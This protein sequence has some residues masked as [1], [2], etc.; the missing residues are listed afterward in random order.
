[1]SSFTV[2]KDPSVMNEDPSLSLLIYPR[3]AFAPVAHVE[4]EVHGRCYTLVWCTGT[5]MPKLAHKIDKVARGGLPFYQVE[6]DATPEQCCELEYALYTSRIPALNCIHG[7]S[8]ALSRY[9]D[10]HIPFPLSIVPS[11]SLA[12]LK[13][14]QA[15]GN[16]RIKQITLHGDFSSLESRAKVAANTSLGPVC[17]VALVLVWVWIGNL[18]LMTAL[19]Y[20]EEVY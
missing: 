15:L 9:A 8:R 18:T 10:V 7:A 1:M 4:L 13:A 14:L 11:V 17:E 2:S 19:S 16:R 5:L 20:G 12:Y 6:I 3:Q